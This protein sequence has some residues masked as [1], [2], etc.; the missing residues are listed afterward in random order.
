MIRRDLRFFSIV[1]TS[2]FWLC[3]LSFAN[4]S[5]EEWYL[6]GKEAIRAK[7][8]SL[9]QST[10]QQLSNSNLKPYLEFNYLHARVNDLPETEITQFLTNHRG[11]DFYGMLSNRFFNEQ[12]KKRN[13]KVILDNKPLL[14]TLSLRC[15]GY[16]AAIEAYNEFDSA[17][18]K[19]EWLSVTG[20]P[21]T[22]Q[23]AENKLLASNQLTA[24]E[25]T[26]KI[27]ERLEKNYITQAER[28]INHLPQKNQGYYRY[29]VKLLRN[30]SSV[31]GEKTFYSDS[32][33]LYTQVIHAWSKNN[34]VAAQ[35]GLD[36]LHARNL[37]EPKDY[38]Y[39]RNRLATFQAGRTD[40]ENRLA[41]FKAIPANEGSDAVWEWGFRIAMQEGDY[42]L[43]TT[44]LDRLSDS[45]KADEVWRFWRGYLYEIVG[46]TARANAE[47]RAIKDRFSF[48][49]F[50]ASDRLNEPY[51]ALNTLVKERMSRPSTDNLPSDFYLALSL[52][53][54]D[55]EFFG[56][57]RWLAALKNANA[58]TKHAASLLAEKA[59]Y[60]N[61]SLMAGTQA[62][63]TGGLSLRYPS[64]YQ[65]TIESNLN[66]DPILTTPLVLGLIRQESLFH[67][68]AKSPA[69]AY[70]LMQLLMPTAQT[71]SRELKESKR[72]SLYNPTANIRYGVAYLKKV[73]SDVG[74]CVPYLLAS[75]NAGPHKVK[76]WKKHEIDDI[77]LWIESI[78]YYETRN[79][80]KSV[81]GNTM[82]YHALLGK[83]AR[84]SDY[85]TCP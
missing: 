76:V 34:S 32:S 53:N 24:H 3:N 28:L 60:Y 30:P 82:I 55:E 7:N 15:I 51:T 11:A 20:I 35:Q 83:P 62:K 21:G 78:P 73:E 8:W 2:I 79:Y 31:M 39:L 44:F 71:V 40:V 47:Y 13:Y 58:N 52:H 67:I 19:K 1:L 46:D 85:L 37:L 70:G 56:R 38:R 84:I 50:L 68:K 75:Y 72:E 6:K 65:I 41:L 14:N 12:L 80:V 42:A 4:T 26:Q 17:N 54:V 33:A 16:D 43:A 49:G 9:Y 27:M 23:K 29:F 81:L 5:H 22:C 25:L 48:Y 57:L 59:G 64:P 45:A 10:A 74:A 61:L 18:F 66:R 77:V 69:N 36:F 63:A